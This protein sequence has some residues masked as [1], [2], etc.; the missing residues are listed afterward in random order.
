MRLFV[1]MTRIALLTVHMRLFPEQVQVTL[2]LGEL[3]GGA[4]QQQ[5][6][7]LG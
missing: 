2:A 3:G 1:C 7:L 6:L 5:M 4:G